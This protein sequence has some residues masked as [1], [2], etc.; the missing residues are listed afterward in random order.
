MQLVIF[1]FLI[2]FLISQKSN[3]RFEAINADNGLS[4]NSVYAIGQDGKGFLWFGTQDG[5]NRFDGINFEIFKK[6]PF[7]S[8]SIQ[9]NWI[10]VIRTDQ[11]GNLWIGT[12]NG[13][14]VHFDI[15]QEKLTNYLF[16]ENKNSVSHNRVWDIFIEDEE[17]IWIGTLNGLNLYNTRTKLFTYF[18][19]ISG[20][21]QKE[22][23]YSVNSIKK[24]SAGELIIGVWN[25]PLMIFSKQDLKLKA[26]DETYSSQNKVS[27]NY[28]KDL[29]I[30]DEV[31]WIATYDGGLNKYSFKTKHY[32]VYRFSYQNK[33]SISSD[34]LWNLYK[35]S[36][37]NIWISSRGGGLNRYN[38]TL[39]NFERFNHNDLDM[40]SFS[41]S[42]ATSI[43][44]DK[45]GLMWFG[46]AGNG[47]NKF[48]NRTEKFIFIDKYQHPDLIT[49][50]IEE[51]HHLGN[52]TYLM[53]SYDKGLIYYDRN[54]YQF[55]HYEKK[56]NYNN[57]ISSNTVWEI[58]QID[59]D[60]FL[61]GTTN[62]INLYNRKKEAFQKISFKKEGQTDI[63][64]NISEIVK[65]NNN[66]FW[67]GTWGGGLYKINLKEKSYLH[68]SNSQSIDLNRQIPSNYIS[69]LYNDK[70]G[71]LW[72]GT[73]DKAL[74]RLLANGK[75][76]T[77]DHDPKRNNSISG[78]Y[79]RSI[80]QDAN[81]RVWIGTYD[82]G[83]SLFLGVNNTFKHF[84]LAKG[85]LSNTIAS[86][87]LD[88]KDN[89]WIGTD[90][91][92]VQFN[93]NDYKT[94]IFDQSNGLQGN[95][96]NSASL[97]IKE[98][99][100][101]IFSGSKGFNIFNPDSIENNNF[102]PPV[103]LTA[104]RQ[105]DKIP[106]SNYQII[107]GKEAI[108]LEP[109]QNFIAFEFSS[110]DYHNPQKNKYQFMMQNLTDKWMESGNRRYVSYSYLEPGE[111]IFRV[112][113]SNNEGVWNMAGKSLTIIVGAPFY[114]KWWFQVSSLLFLFIIAFSI[115]RNRV[116]QIKE[117]ENTRYKIAQDL[118]DE[119]GGTLSSISYFAEAVDII[120]QQESND[121]KKINKLLK[122]IKNSALSAQ[123]AIGDIIWSISPKNDKWETIISKMQRYAADL[124]D[125]KKIKY[126]LNL[127]HSKEIYS[128]D[129]HKRQHLWRIYKEIVTNIA[130]H[131]DCTSAHLEL[132][133]NQKKIFLEISDDGKGFD[134]NEE[135]SRN[136]IKNIKSRVS[137]LNG[138]LN[139][140]S[141]ENIGTTWKIEFTV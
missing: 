126:K 120:Q 29:L 113:G 134:V 55:K 38:K 22:K 80:V 46:T 48:N 74:F 26:F 24:L 118:H 138:S 130:K 34:L 42:H 6:S 125:S 7:D 110:L 44:E 61:I 86:I 83:L 93:T 49:N 2:T 11:L 47:V 13:G 96:F 5:L 116:M 52:Q 67:I 1:L 100:E 117:L 119:I 19:F 53:G 111:Y 115:Y 122:S 94:R 82:G 40:L 62:G 30:D 28:I 89:L 15:H 68:Y 114:M 27:S 101:L 106:F 70:A 63:Y 136:G 104:Y 99:N 17:N 87:S 50:N 92:L 141:K 127:Q 137:Y 43:F 105:F 58:S 129:M 79:V 109:E 37:G 135:T 77:F 10:Q 8:L 66:S 64:P 35:D 112:R 69:A 71:I 12:H 78:V 33:K 103:V 36:R 84:S 133:M 102:I 81:E 91:G 123:E 57:E 90:K 132:S 76:E 3:I 65:I 4:N 72:V 88:S 131:S 124:F 60:N 25:E 107:N 32:T 45:S 39:D 20:K 108:F 9:D 16:S 128:L 41:H 140:N 51:I 18:P 31:L 139:I 98:S 56:N 59:T 54:K 85:F 73:V 121:K 21:E 14:I 75:I 97:Y 95:Q 23:P